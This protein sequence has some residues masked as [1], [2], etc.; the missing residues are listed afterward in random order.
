MKKTF[1]A[2]T[3]DAGR[4]VQRLLHDRLG[5]ANAEAK[6]LIASGCV[7]RN[8][9]VAAKPDE[10]VAPMRRECHRIAATTPVHR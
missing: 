5:L 6:G 10:R 3:G 9:R 2:E 1:R 8:R 7:R 4:T